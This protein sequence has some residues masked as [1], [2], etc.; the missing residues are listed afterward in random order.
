VPADDGC[1]RCCGLR[2][3]RQVG[4]DVM[5]ADDERHEELGLPKWQVDSLAEM[6]RAERRREMMVGACDLSIT[7]GLP[8]PGSGE[9]YANATSA[10]M[11]QPAGVGLSV[12]AAREALAPSICN[13]GAE[14][15]SRD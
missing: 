9:W 13:L 2:L 14:A 11:A 1:T 5:G 10:A 3:G 15:T 8:R 7:G 6:E 4:D 12:A